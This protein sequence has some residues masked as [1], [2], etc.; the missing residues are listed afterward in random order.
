MKGQQKMRK[1][2]FFRGLAL[3]L[4]FTLV[5]TMCPSLAGVNNVYADT[6]AL[7]IEKPEVLVTGTGVVGD[8]S[9]TEGNVGLEKAYT[10][11]EMK[12]MDGGVNVVY[13]SIKS[14]EPYTKEQ[15]TASGVYLSSLLKGTAFDAAKDKLTLMA[16]DGY[17]VSF[18]PNAEYKLGSR[19]TTGFAE[20]RYSFPGLLS[21]SDADSVA[22]DT[23]IAWAYDEDTKAAPE[24]AGE[25]QK[26]LR[27]VAGQLSFEDQNKP[28]FNGGSKASMQ[29]VQAGDA[30]T[31]TA[32]TV[33]TTE[34]TR[35]EVL[36]MER[37]ERSYSYSSS[38]GDRTDAVVG[39]PMSVLLDEYDET[40]VVTFEAADGYAV[41]ASGMTVKELIDGNY[42]LGYEVNGEGVYNTAK[43]DDSIVGLLTLYGDDFKPAKMVDSV[44]VTAASG[45][46][47]SKS[48]Y[49]H[50]TNGGLSGETPY[51]IDAITGATL[52]VEGPGVTT[53]VPLPVRDLE[54]RNAGAFRGDYTD[55]RNG[56]E[57]E[58]TYEGIDLY[59]VLNNM[60]EGSNGIIMTDTAKIVELKNRNRD[61][62]ATFTMGQINAAHDAGKPI[63]IAYGTSYT[64]GTNVRPFVFDG[65]TG[66]DKKLGNEDG[67]LK[68]VYDKSVIS[69]DLNGDYTE[70]ASMAYIYVA[71][72]ST[73]GFKHDKAPYNTAENTQYVLT[74]TG[75]E[76]GR[77]VNYKVEDLEAMVE[78]DENGAPVADGFGYRD[79]YKLAN[80]TYWY[81]NE[82]EGVKMWDLLQTA[83]LS[84]DKA[85]DEETI[86]SFTARDG[87]TGFDKFT[88]KQIAD[89][90]CFGYYE[91]NPADNNDGKYT[92]VPED[93]LDT[94]YPVLVAYGVNKYPYVIEKETDGFLSG[95][96]ND[97]GPLRVISGKLN[98]AHAN[99][100]SQAQKLDKII[101]GDD[102]YHYSTHK[103][104]DKDVYK[105]VADEKLT[106]EVVNGSKTIK[107]AEYTVGDIEDL[108][109]GEK[110]SSA[111]VK[112]ARIKGYYEADKNGELY[113][114]LYEGV[115]LSYFLK[116]VVEIP[117]E[118]GT[119][120]FNQGGEDEYSMDLSALLT[121]TDGYNTDTELSGLAPVLAFAK[122]GY[123]MVNS[124]EEA[125]GYVKNFT[126][127]EGK[128]E[129]KFDVK[130][131]GGALS[132][133]I[134][135][136]SKEAKDAKAVTNVT[137]IT[138]NLSADKYA[139]LEAPYDT[140]ATETL[141][142]S[143]EGTRQTEPKV[144]TVGELE[145]KQTIAET[146]VYSVLKNGESEASQTRFR[147]LNVY[148]LLQQYGLK[149]NA[150]KVIFTDSEGKTYEFSLSDVSR[151][152]K[153]TVTGED[154]NMILAYGSA[155]ADNADAEDGLPLVAG[156]D[157]EGYD[158]AYGNNGGPLKLVVGQLDAADVNSSKNIKDVVAIEV[159]A[160]EQVSWDHNSAEV[161]KQ[162]LDYSIDFIVYNEVDTVNPIYTKKITVAEIEAM[163]H[164]V[165]RE[166]IYT[167]TEDEWEGVNLWGMVQEQMKEVPG[168]FTVVGLSPKQGSYGPELIG[169]FGETALKDGIE[170]KPIL[171]AYAINGKP[172][173]PG[174]T[175]T[176]TQNGEGYDAMATNNGGPLRTV[177]HKSTGTCIQELERIEV[178]VR[179]E[180]AVTPTDK[181]ETS[182]ANGQEGQLPFA[183]VRSVSFNSEDGMWVGTYGGGAAYK[184]AGADTYTIY[185]E[186]S[187]LDTGFVS[188]VAADA[189]GGVWM[190]QNASY[191]EPGKNKGVIY[192]DK[193]G[194]M[195]SYTVEG[196][197]GTLPDNYVQDIK[198]DSEG[199]VWFASFGGLT[200]YNPTTNEWKTWTKADSGF[201]AEAV[202]KIEFDGNGGVWLGF[203][204]E[205]TTD[206]NGGV[207]FT[208]G[209]AH[210]TA[211]GTVTS[212][213]L[214]ATSTAE[215][216]SKLAE[217]WIRDLAVANDGSVWVVAS[218]AYAN[219]ENVGGS[220]WHVAAPGA[221]AEAYT[222]D[223]LFGDA[224]DGASNAE[225]RMVAADNNGGLW[226]GTSADGVFYVADPTISTDGTMAITTMY[227]TETGSWTESGMDNVYSLDFH[228]GTVYVGSASGLA[229]LKADALKENAGDATAD[230]A[231][232]SFV[233]NGLV[234]EGHFT[235]KGLKNAEGIEKGEYSFFWMNSSGTTGT[236]V[237]EGA[238]M[239]NIL[240]DI[241]GITDAADTITFICSDGYSKT[242]SLDDMFAKDKDGNRPVMAWKVDGEK[243]DLTLVI[244][245]TAADENNKSKWMKDI[246]KVEVT[247]GAATPDE[248]DTPVVP[249]E[250]ET[251]D[252]VGDADATSADISFVGNGLVKEGYFSI[253][254]L[255][256]AEGIEKAEYTFD[257]M[258][259]KGTTGTSVAEGASMKNILKDILGITDDADTITFICSDGYSKT[260]SLDDMFV[261]D[262][263]GQRPVLAWKVDGE[264]C[265]PTL[266]IGQADENDVNK[267]KWLKEIVKV[268]VTAPAPD[269]ENAGDAA[270]VESADIVFTGEGLVKDGYFTIKGLKNAEGIEKAE[271]TF[272][273]M[274]SKGTTGTSVAEG[275]SMKNILKDILGIT[276]DADTITFICSDG[277]S[278]TM[279]LD[280]MF[281]K[282]KDGQRP[283]LAWKVDGEKCDPTLVIGQA[284][285]ND[286]NKGKWLKEI[287]KVE[288]TVSGGTET[289]EDPT[290]P[291]T[292]IEPE[293]PTE[294]DTP[295][296]PEEPTVETC[297]VCGNDLNEDGL[298]QYLC[299]ECGKHLEEDFQCH[300]R[301]E[302]CDSHLDAEGNC[303]LGCEEID[304]NPEEPS[305]DTEEPVADEDPLTEDEA[306]DKADKDASSQTGDD[307]NMAIYFGMM[308]LALAVAGAA[309]F[310]RR[311]N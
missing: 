44:S 153:N 280:D 97:G 96:S 84:A 188:A 106:I 53:S 149:S 107:S 122:N 181:F 290:E 41:D 200:K 69:G 197:P 104:N 206:G 9:Y 133:L 65:A 288:V 85:T 173:V 234:N 185:N 56:V 32:L 130:N 51:N 146:A 68:L 139:H 262:K 301:C 252:A 124:K 79:E 282:D 16:D 169:K 126:T 36:L 74:I 47:Y 12:A 23:M 211:D 19:N 296:V 78:Y 59:Y 309:L 229:W 289:P 113:S 273:W 152:Y 24:T 131:N 267:G 277:Y 77:E 254:G 3:A 235:V 191:T 179:A 90:D 100:S 284:D 46:D 251:G 83:G 218:G 33:G 4:V 6:N 265:D 260:M 105:K 258:N 171:L 136:T 306:A 57:T 256:N 102:T 194:N 207:P 307:S 272:D 212:Y 128:Y 259:S 205:G 132:V 214:T 150:D 270:D 40:D 195:T 221:E 49:K 11:D 91:K 232:I 311:E 62:V 7:T 222:G 308:I 93:L 281:V 261:K 276:D 162:Y 111:A 15:N 145:A 147:G 285:E 118:K 274:N 45:I 76:I 101:V 295:V 27:L 13:S 220:V 166:V 299:E 172:M 297:P 159:T 58:R 279:S 303:P 160:S 186:N 291:D 184:A 243:C 257:W 21:G 255:K 154:V 61:T 249:D 304:W 196:N 34:Y 294:P 119:V 134:P 2:P 75:D 30:L 31:G 183:G 224:L 193:D 140:Y 192:M 66:A 42:M 137:S 157:S 300:N 82:Y 240:K 117:G 116:N 182:V 271:Y 39:V 247:E 176:G 35:G 213:P 38:K 227:N 225:L 158:K 25:E 123:P 283:V 245:Q 210:M 87:Y 253:K 151:K 63:L 175:K 92:G 167:S 80:N 28:L 209:F 17:A 187:G 8:A 156:K 37:A 217:V 266:V 112:E 120:T 1:H 89:P 231:D 287:V 148:K 5:V 238:S 88:L 163:T 198:I 208:G 52:T 125:D 81:V 190:S 114:D 64:D 223:Q 230:T 14:Q 71:E 199:N 95:L 161:Y 269:K 141:T 302:Y 219:I 178:V 165:E 204:P 180:G 50:I 233:G 129:T 99:G 98:Y 127:G 244:G 177:T 237:V 110:V 202:T 143:G 305:E 10:R 54:N 310:R 298:C 264:K 94:G 174:S 216:T 18:D 22:V 115:N 242:M 268:E 275:A 239:K 189:N 228:K 292:P 121:L 286:V 20:K 226:F 203:Y 278:K 248:P 60:S 108:L 164:L 250:P 73:P 86:V 142:I 72:E 43:N 26:N 168:E 103:Y 48:P 201:P 293:D 70:F 135:N 55:I 236:S 170:G 109:Y 241:L 67:C 246:V 215:G 29:V 138:I 155:P 144:V 263:D